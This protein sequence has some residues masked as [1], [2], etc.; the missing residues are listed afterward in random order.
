MATDSIRQDSKLLLSA[1]GLFLVLAL[2]VLSV[3]P[4]TRLAVSGHLPRK[5]VQTFYQPLA[6]VNGTRLE[7]L[8]LW[9]MQLWLPPT[10]VGD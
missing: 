7:S 4:A 3:G 8:R 5:F 6:I 9:Y 2:Y 1:C 10:Y